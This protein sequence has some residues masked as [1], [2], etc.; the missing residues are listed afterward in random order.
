[1]RFCDELAFAFGWV[2]DED[3][4]R[5]AAHALVDDDGGVWL[6][7][8]LEWPDALARVVERGPA[9]GVIQL[10]DRHARDGAAISER[11]GVPLHV[12]PRE[13]LAGIG[14]RFLN[15]ARRAWNEVALWWPERR[16]LVA[17]D[18]LGTVAYF[19]APTEPIGVHPLLRVWPP[20]ELRRVYPEHILCGHGEGVHVDAT[21]ALHSALRTAR[22]RL[23][24][25]VA[26]G[27]R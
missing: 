6:V 27:F 4:I 3:R 25:A 20:R 7:D 11:L 23:P 2:D 22:R 12:V 26:N 21:R 18:V 5:R 8:P 13:P 10:L 9:R 24:A 1:M 19:R 16:T 14:F 15:V 17:A